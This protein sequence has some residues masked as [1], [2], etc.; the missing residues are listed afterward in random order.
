MVI[1]IKYA[2]VIYAVRNKT[3]K[4][5]KSSGLKDPRMESN[6]QADDTNQDTNIVTDSI[7]KAIGNVSKELSK[8]VSSVT[9]GD[10]ITT[11]A[12]VM[13]STWRETNKVGLVDDIYNY[14]VDFAVAE[15]LT[16]ARD[17]EG[18]RAYMKTAE[19]SL[20]NAKI[21]LYDKKSP[22]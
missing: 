19:A 1:T 14:L 5:G 13:P 20:A 21:K 11:I 18:A 10:G 2:D 8:Y 12:F 22:I 3:H 4:L 6:M 16:S 15:F 9:P 17:G 7:G